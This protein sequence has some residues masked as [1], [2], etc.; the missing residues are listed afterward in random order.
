[1]HNSHYVSID[2]VRDIGVDSIRVY[3]EE[4]YDCVH[5]NYGHYII[6]P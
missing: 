1:M 4:G 2:T 5:I 6:L 3:F